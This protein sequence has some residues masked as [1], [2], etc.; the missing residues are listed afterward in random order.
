MASSP[1]GQLFS[2]STLTT[3]AQA[4][5]QVDPELRFHSVKTCLTS[6]KW[7]E[8]DF[9]PP[10]APP[11]RPRPC[12]I[13]DRSTQFTSSLWHELSK[14]WASELHHTTAYHPQANGLI[15]RF[16]CQL[17]DALRAQ[18]A[19]PHWYH[20]LPWV[21][22]GIRCP[23]KDDIQMS[24]AQLLYGASLKV[25]GAL[26]LHPNDQ[27][28]PTQHFRNLRERLA[29][30]V[31]P[32]S[33]FHGKPNSFVP[34]LLHT[35]PFVWVRVDRVQSSLEP[36]YQGPIAVLQRQPKSF[37][38]DMDDKKRHVSLD[39]LKPAFF[40]DSHPL[41]TETQ[42]GRLIKAPARYRSG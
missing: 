18:L 3:L 11:A 16:H 7:E 12:I 42:S 9:T 38:R 23:P 5:Q 34:P 41:P 14:L 39:Q 28:T 19:G 35:C 29:H 24:P 31:P 37:L 32:A 1:T 2:S 25:P 10:P 40:D 20:H 26:C 17:K 22:F 4:Q 36:P 8:I 21:L 15:E 27:T 30:L 33:Q 6:L 13:T